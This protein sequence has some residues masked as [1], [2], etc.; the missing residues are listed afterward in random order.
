MSSLKWT[1]KESGH[2]VSGTWHVK[3]AGTNWDLYNGRKHIAPGK[4]KKECQQLAENPPAADPDDDDATPAERG[5]G[6]KPKGAVKLDDLHGVM[7]SLYLEMTHITTSVTENAHYNKKLSESIDKLTNAVL[8]LG[9]HVAKL[10]TEK[11]NA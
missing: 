1:R 4:S 2:Y 6:H 5:T 11:K 8:I 3:G 10:N 9:K 7:T